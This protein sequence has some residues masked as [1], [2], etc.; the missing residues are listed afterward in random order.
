MSNLLL[1]TVPMGGYELEIIS[2]LERKGFQVDYFKEGSKIHRSRLTFWQRT[3]RV[4]VNDFQLKFLRPVLDRMEEKI[5][6]E[7]ILKLS[8]NYEYV[9]DFGGHAYAKCLE[10]LREKYQARFI[11]F[12]WD[13]MQYARTA[14]KTKGYFDRKYIFNRQ[15]AEAYGFEYR[16]S[17]FANQYL[18]KDEDKVIDVFYKGSARDRK[19]SVI[20]NEIAKELRGYKLD[21]SLFARGG[22]LR[23]LLKVKDRNFFNAWCNDEYLNLTQ[24]AVKCKKS[25]VVLDIS[26]KNQKG[27][28][29]RPLEALAANCK[30]ITT[31]ENIKKY[32]FYDE[33]NVFYLANDLSNI[34]D[35]ASFI[36]K[37]LK[38]YKPEVRRRYSI[39]GFLD[40]IFDDH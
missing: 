36:G 25:K 11:L 32:D 9:F 2:G 17:F 19:R 22:Y 29:L 15:D 6:R 35:L 28:S 14:L 5:Y 8:K 4:F 7:H 16:P 13:D 12:V 1:I 20:L 30:I 37:P 27:L 23:N 18:Y 34:K 26:Y 33:S 24:L 38:K 31:N 3:I 40:E 39:D 10:I 21:F